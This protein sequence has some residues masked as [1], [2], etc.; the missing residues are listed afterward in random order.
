[1]HDV[2]HNTLLSSI[3]FVGVWFDIV[4]ELKSDNNSIATVIVESASSS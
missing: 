3:N 4:V 1:M 2:T